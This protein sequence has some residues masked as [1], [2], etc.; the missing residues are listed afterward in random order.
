M[1]RVSLKERKTSGQGPGVL[2]AAEEPCGVRWINSGVSS[3]E[4][5]S[6][7]KKYCKESLSSKI[8]NEC[9][10]ETHIFH[11]QDMTETENIQFLPEI[12]LS[13]LYVLC[14]RV[15]VDTILQ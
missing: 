15:L 1:Q 6:L 10:C 2:R 4:E 12:S 7:V 9:V 13:N 14:M 11:K 8:P 3:P 5:T